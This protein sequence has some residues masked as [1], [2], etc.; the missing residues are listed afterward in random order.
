[1]TVV[2]VA[3]TLCVRKCNPLSVSMLQANQ[4]VKGNRLSAVYAGSRR[5]SC[6]GSYGWQYLSRPTTAYSARQKSPHPC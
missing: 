3:V 4:E 5:S 1:L 2:A 6:Y